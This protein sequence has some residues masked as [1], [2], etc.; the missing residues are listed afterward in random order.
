MCEV[1]VQLHSFAF[2]CPVDP[3][4][5]V[6]NTIL[7][8]LNCTGSLIENNLPINVKVYLLT[9]SC[10]LLIYMSNLMLE[11]HCPFLI[12]SWK[13]RFRRKLQSR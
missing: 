2:G 6:E 10:I 8:T 1:K 4:L 7:S 9:L 11:W 5:F 3:E 13:V 12:K